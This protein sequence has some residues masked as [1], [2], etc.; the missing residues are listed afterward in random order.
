M[1]E[2]EGF[3]SEYGREPRISELAARCSVTQEEASEALEACSE[4]S[5]LSAPLGEDGADARGLAARPCRQDNRPNRQN[6]ACAG[7]LEAVGQ[8]TA[9]HNAALLRRSVAEANRGAARAVTGKD[10]ARREKDTRK[11]QGCIIAAI[12]C[13]SRYIRLYVA[14]RSSTHTRRYWLI[15]FGAPQRI[16]PVPNR[17][18]ASRARGSRPYE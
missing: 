11:A 9:N 10:I 13:I 6:S 15:G 1:R 7:S 4:I 14:E 8:R 17:L 3:I 12:R 16:C 18:R 2:R 5:S